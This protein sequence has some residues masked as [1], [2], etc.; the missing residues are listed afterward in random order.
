MDTYKHTIGEIEDVLDQTEEVDMRG[1][2][3]A[4]LAWSQAMR[5]AGTAIKISSVKEHANEGVL[6][7]AQVD[8]IK[9]LEDAASEALE[10]VE[11]ASPNALKDYSPTAEKV[12]EMIKQPM[13]PQHTEIEDLI[14]VFGSTEAEALALLAVRE[15]QERDELSTLDYSQIETQLQVALDN[16]KPVNITGLNAFTCKS[17]YIKLYDKIHANTE[18][19]KLAWLKTNMPRKRLGIEAQVMVLNDI[20]DGLEDRTLVLEREMEGTTQSFSHMH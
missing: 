4:S 8:Y 5:Y 10:L 11:W 19:L 17:M 12:V 16:T 9:K 3:Y 18:R 14:R 15:T 13:K 20:K 2:L 6:T 7:D 1:S